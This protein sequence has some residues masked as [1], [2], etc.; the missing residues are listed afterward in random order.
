MRLFT[1]Q[2]LSLPVLSADL[3]LVVL[4]REDQIPEI[5]AEQGLAAPDRHLLLGLVQAA[6]IAVEEQ[7]SESVVFVERSAIRLNSC[8]EWHQLASGLAIAKSKEGPFGV[9]A[10][11]GHDVACRVARQAVRWFTARIRLDVP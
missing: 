9:L 4:L 11:G 1:S 6:I 5:F 7:D 10:A 2:S 3:E 8:E